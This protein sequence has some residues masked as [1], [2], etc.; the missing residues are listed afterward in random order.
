[1]PSHR[2]HTLGGFFLV[3]TLV[4]LLY[5]N[6][7]ELELYYVVKTYKD[8]RVEYDSGPYKS[9]FYAER[10]NET[11]HQWNSKEYRIVKETKAVETQ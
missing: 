8:G 5:N 6:I 7:M 2:P 9:Y 1:M 4:K 11:E 3:D 10:A